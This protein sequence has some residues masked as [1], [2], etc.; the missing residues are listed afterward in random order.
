VYGNIFIYTLDYSNCETMNKIEEFLS[1]CDTKSTRKNYTS[2]LKHFFTTINTDPATYFDNERNYDDDIMSYWQGLSKYAPCTRIARISCVKLL[3]EENDINLSTKTKKKLKR[4]TRRSKPITLDVIPTNQELKQILQRAEMK[5]RALFLIAS[6]SGMRINEILQLEPD[7][8]DLN[9]DPVKIYIRAETT[10]TKRARLT[11]MSNEAKEALLEWLKERDNYLHSAVAKTGAITGKTLDDPTIFCFAYGTALKIWHRLLEQSGF[12]Q[13]D[14][15]TGVHRM[16]EHVLRKFFETRMSYAGIPEAIYQQLEGHEG[17]L[18]GS[19]KRFTDQELAESYKKGVKN[20][21]V[22]ETQSD[23]RLNDLDE[24]LKEKDKEIQDL[25]R[26]MD[27]LNQ[28]MLML[29]AKNQ[30]K[31]K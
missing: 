13:R 29:L 21:L 12:N 15:Q 10:K 25:K 22:F 7:D 27:D 19:Y 3:F 11:F 18:N 28:T 23:E 31:Q 5:A 24:Q 30:A 26:K 9:S 8:I 16:H 17:Y 14:K 1:E 4:K 6:S 2:H 20:L